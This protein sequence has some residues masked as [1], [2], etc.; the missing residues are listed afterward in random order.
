VRNDA[1]ACHHYAITG[2]SNNKERLSVR[3]FLTFSLWRSACRTFG[4]HL[5]QMQLQIQNIFYAL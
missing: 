5:P 3:F 4:V 1:E 2:K